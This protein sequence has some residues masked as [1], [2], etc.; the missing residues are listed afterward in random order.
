MRTLCLVLL[1]GALGAAP[2]CREITP[3]QLVVWVDTDLP[4][5]VFDRIE[6]R[7]DG[8]D[9]P[10]LRRAV[11]ALPVSFGIRPKRDDP[12]RRVTVE[13]SASRGG[14]LLLETASATTFLEHRRLRLDIFLSHQCL[15]VACP[16]GQT[17]RR[18]TCEDVAVDPHGLPPGDDP[19]DL[20]DAAVLHDAAPLDASVDAPMSDAAPS[21][22]APSD[23]SVDAGPGPCVPCEALA[24]TGC[25]EGETCRYYDA[26]CS[27]CETP[28]PAAEGMLCHADT[29][30][31][32]GLG[33]VLVEGAGTCQR[34]CGA[35]DECGGGVACLVL[36]DTLG[37]C[38]GTCDPMAADCAADTQCALLIGQSV[39]GAAVPAF[40]CVGEGTGAAG[41]ACGVLGCQPGMQCTSVDGLPAGIC[42]PF[43][44]DEADCAGLPCGAF[45]DGAG[46][47]LDVGL[48]TAD[49][50]PVRLTGCPVGQHCT[51]V[52]A[53]RPGDEVAL[54]ALQCTPPGLTALG[55]DCSV[56][57]CAL[58][59]ACVQDTCRAICE[60]D[61]DPCPLLAPCRST[62]P[63]TFVEG[64][65]YGYC[66]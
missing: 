6:V 30:C 53:R 44:E 66:G 51:L 32:A 12:R 55:G 36:L 25:E 39:E 59:L 50:D 9:G 4:A 27:R 38:A 47:H 13:A 5:T 49:C 26:D 28:G 24:G 40:L 16:P 34:Y 57:P 52:V 62:V 1:V 17:C 60:V 45:D 33:C 14:E 54:F 46:G 37:I 21:D 65:E 2:G 64:H 41:E 8:P 19:P 63:P 20:A 31:G 3:T 15:R 42:S 18:G 61:G 7:V 58:G 48:C 56:E 23:A 10:A 43:C 35:S 11:D 22:A 29:D